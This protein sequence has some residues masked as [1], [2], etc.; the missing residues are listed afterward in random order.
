MLADIEGTYEGPPTGFFW[1]GNSLSYGSDCCQQSAFFVINAPSKVR[2]CA[3][4]PGH[5]RSEISYRALATFQN[6]G[7]KN[8]TRDAISFNYVFCSYFDKILYLF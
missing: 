1:G 7:K 8:K 6:V 5:L 4:P 3:P 2:N